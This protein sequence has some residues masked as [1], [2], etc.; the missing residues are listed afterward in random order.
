MV[1]RA[2]VLAEKLSALREATARLQRLQ[3]RDATDEAVAWAIER[4]LQIAAQAVFDTGN[5]LLAGAFSVRAA[6]YSAVP[7]LLHRHGVLTK[8]LCDRLAGLAGFRNLLVHDYARVDIGRVR[9][10]LA[11]RL[12]DF[13]DFATEVES[14]LADAA[15]DP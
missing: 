9:A 5:H 11:T 3:S 15:R 1:V 12:Q 8:A 13:E 10:L 7:E 6:D 2:E 14:W 4:G